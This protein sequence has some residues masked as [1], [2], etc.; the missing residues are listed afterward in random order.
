[1]KIIRFKVPKSD[2]AGGSTSQD[3]AE[4]RTTLPSETLDELQP[5]SDLHADNNNLTSSP[6]KMAPATHSDQKVVEDEI[7]DVIQDLYQ[8][9][10]QTTTRCLPQEGP[11]DC[12]LLLLEPTP[13]PPELLTY[14]D[15]GR[16]PDIYTREFAEGAR[17]SNQLI[18]G[19]MEA[20]GEFRDVLATEMAKVYPELRGDIGK[21]LDATGGRRNVVLEPPAEG[22]DEVPGS[23]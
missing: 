15:N 4:A 8:I 23:G 3:A 20:F 6:E 22:E 12:H 2:D 7:K 9:M 16:N 21:I 5:P 14:V 10:V 18:K 1:M 13:R 17:R 19:K 11:H